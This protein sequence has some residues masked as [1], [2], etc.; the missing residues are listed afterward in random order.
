[1][2]QSTRDVTTDRLSGNVCTKSSGQEI[3]YDGHLCEGANLTPVFGSDNFCL[4]FRC[5]AADVPADKAHQGDISEVTCLK[6]REIW[7]EE[8]GQFGVGA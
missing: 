6:C 5:G 1:M 8:N 4:W 3:V 7:D 2:N